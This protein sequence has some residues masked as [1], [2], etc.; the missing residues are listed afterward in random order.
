MGVIQK[1]T[2]DG[3]T[4]LIAST[5]YGE[6]TTEGATAAKTV[7]ITGD[8]TTTVP[9]TLIKGT[10]IHVKFTNVNSAENPTL[11]V[12]STG[13]KPIVKYGT[14]GVGTLSTRAWHGGSVVALTYDGTSW[15]I[16]S[17][18]NGNEGQTWSSVASKISDAQTPAFGATFNIEDVTQ[19]TLGQVAT[20]LRTVTI[21]STT[22]TTSAAG[23]MS[24]SDKSALDG[25]ATGATVKS[26]ELSWG[27]GTTKTISDLTAAKLVSYMPV[28]S[29][30]DVVVIDCKT[31]AS[32]TTFSVADANNTPY[33]LYIKYIG[34]VSWT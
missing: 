17:Y 3:N 27:S 28:D 20:T 7:N 8:G 4:H 16:D 6:C 32:G 13:A 10:T 25:L 2:A 14:T 1:V 9:F 34:T 19:T 5:A 18:K 33:K 26:I 23:L 22:A 11:N 24:A 12:N 31:S 30:D 29:N 21:P 15:V